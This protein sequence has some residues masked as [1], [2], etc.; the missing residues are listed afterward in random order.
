MV[1]A[2]ITKPIAQSM[3]TSRTT[4][5][6]SCSCAGCARSCYANHACYTDAATVTHSSGSASMK[7]PASIGT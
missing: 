5:C 2:G 7:I 6:L 1:G 3:T 4:L